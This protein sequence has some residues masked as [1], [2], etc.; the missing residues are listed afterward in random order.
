MTES[1]EY[2]E[3]YEHPGNGY[4][5]TMNFEGW[6]VA[7]LAYAE[8]FGRITKLE[9]HTLTDEVFVLLKGSATLILGEELQSIDML[10]YKLYNVKKN[11]W[12]AI[13]VSKYAKVLI[14]ENHN[15]SL[16]NT[17]YKNIPPIEPPFES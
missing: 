5:R 8:R 10:P 1:N 7:F 12:H 4:E 16:E 6:R 11:A 13:Q 3:I 14:V 17:F 9:K 2:L 15:T